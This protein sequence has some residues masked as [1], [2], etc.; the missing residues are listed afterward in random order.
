VTRCLVDGA[1]A[2]GGTIAARLARAGV[3]VRLV[4]RGEHLAAIRRD[5]LTLADPDGEDWFRIPAFERPAEA[6]VEA[7]E[8]V[9]G[10]EDAGHGRRARRAG[11]L[12]PVPGVLD[13]GPAVG[14]ASARAEAVACFEAAGIDRADEAEVAARV[15]VVPPIRP[16]GGREWSGSS[17]WQSLARSGGATEVDYINGQSTRT[18]T[19]TSS[20]VAWSDTM[21]SV[22]PMAIGSHNDILTAR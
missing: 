16:V 5:G 15:A 12:R 1:G 13:L 2:I 11:R 4:A 7:N 18:S 21:P 3:E 8:I 6:G 19:K 14:G 10:D 9:A 17:T 22:V 20:W